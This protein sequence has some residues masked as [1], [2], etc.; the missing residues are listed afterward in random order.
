MPPKPRLA[1][2]ETLDPA[3][4][5]LKPSSSLPDQRRSRKAAAHLIDP[6]IVVM[7]P[8]LRAPDQGSGEPAPH[9]IDP[10]KD[11]MFTNEPPRDQGGGPS[12][13]ETHTGIAVAHSID[14]TKHAPEPLVRAS[15]QVGLGHGKASTH[16]SNAEPGQPSPQG[17]GDDL[18]SIDPH[19]GNVIP[20][21]VELWRQRQDLRRA[22]RRLDLQCQAICRRASGG[23]KEAAGKL[24]ALIC[25][26]KSDNPGLTMLLS[27]Y[28]G[29]MDR[30]SASAKA[31]EKEL[32]KMVR[33]MPLWT[34]W[35]VNVRGMAELSFAG[36]V[37]EAAR[38][39]SEYRSVSAL[40]KRFGLAVIEGERQRLVKGDAALVHGYAPQRRAY[41]YTLSTNLM[42]SQ[43]A[44]DP[45]RA[46]YDRR[47][48]YEMERG[49]PKAHAHNRALRVMVKELLKHAWVADRALGR[50]PTPPLAAA[51]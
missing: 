10:A 25:A 5:V 33:K 36:M 18:S 3:I 39:V 16:A 9:A 40:W 6:A 42:R 22:E 1:L 11:R 4:V 29:A 23:D 45:Y 26:D 20:L 31:L 44:E 41:A 48:A 28:T 47:K 14:P 51:A 17:A 21:L 50:P 46:L 32:I 19:T 8:A 38:A 37:G 12:V 15:D 7:E 2:S 34:G 43:R 30:L 24:W 13:P 49:L 27:P 35:A